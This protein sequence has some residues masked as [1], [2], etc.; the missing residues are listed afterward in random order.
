MSPLK[1]ATIEFT[2]GMEKKL[3]WR[4]LCVIPFLCGEIA[5]SFSEVII[6]RLE[7]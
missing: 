3:F 7:I 2:E 6:I 5:T 4:E 1:K